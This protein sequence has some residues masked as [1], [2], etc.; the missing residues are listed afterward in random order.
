MCGR[1]ALGGER[2]AILNDIL[3][4]GI[5]EPDE[6]AEWLDREDYHPRYNI[7][8]RSRAPVIRRRQ[9]IDEDSALNGNNREQSSSEAENSAT[10]E[11]KQ[12]RTVVQTMRWGLVPKNA[13]TDDYKLTANT[14]NARAE[15]I[16]EKGPGRG[17]WGNVIES[18]RCIIPCDGYYEWLTKDAKTR[19]PHF[20]RHPDKT[21]KLYFAGMWDRIMF[22]SEN[23]DEQTKPLYT[24]T[25]VTIPAPPDMEWL[26]DRS[27]LI[28]SPTSPED[29]EKLKVWLN[30]DIHWENGIRQLLESYLHHSLP[31]P[32]TIYQVPKEVGKVGAESKSFTE[33][34]AQRKDGIK[35]MFAK[36]QQ[37]SNSPES[38]PSKR[39]RS[40]T[41]EKMSSS[42]EDSPRKRVK[43]EAPSSPSKAS[44]STPKK[45]PS[46][47]RKKAN[48]T[49][50]KDPNI[51]S[52]SDF[53][54]T[55]SPRK[56]QP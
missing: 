17:T 22:P 46:S 51:R 36:Q 15:T 13:K 47:P 21:K 9:N 56:T 5:F 3:G 23:P 18:R 54:A 12:T 37:K 20:I 1:F 24:F 40:S 44:T 32:Y 52:I 4:A 28:F 34:I 30:P 48:N 2:D 43:Q 38:L 8:P 31:E 53:F 26:H 16:L 7:A 6:D 14:I 25:I 19:L 27:P 50:A 35:A 33:P 41:P 11:H 29:M 42:V 55:A 49:P 10:P 45:A 39:P